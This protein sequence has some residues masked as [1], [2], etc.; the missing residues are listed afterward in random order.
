MYFKD[1]S[2]F[3]AMGG[4][5]VFVWLAYGA[6]LL[7]IAYNVMAPALARKKLKAQ[8]LRQ[9]QRQILQNNGGS[10][11]NAQADKQKI[12]KEHVKA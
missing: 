5:G 2:S 7:V 4:H 8:F 10:S 3:I 9:K 1:I 12:T 11:V 6:T